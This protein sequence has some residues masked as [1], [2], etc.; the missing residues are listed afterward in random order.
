M[1]ALLEGD[2]GVRVNVVNATGGQGVT[3]H[4]RGAR[5]RP[6]GYTLTMMTVELNMLHWRGLTTV[7]PESFVPLVLFNRDPAAVFVRAD[8]PWRTLAELERFVRSGPG[9]LRASGSAQGSI[10]HLALAGWY[11]LL[12]EDPAGL[13]WLPS[14]GAASAMAELL[15]GTVDVVCCSLPEAAVQISAGQVR[16]LGVMSKERVAPA[17]ADVPAFPEQGHDWSIGGWRAVGVPRDTPPEIRSV[18][19]AALERVVGSPAFRHF[20]A[21]QGY[22]WRYEGE[23]D[24]R[25]TVAETDRV[26]GK[27][28]RE[29][30]FST[31]R[32]GRFGAMLFP[33]ALAIALLGLLTALLATGGRGGKQSDRPRPDGWARLAEGISVIVLFI[34]LVRPLGFV[35]TAGCLLGL[36]LFRLGVRP[37]TAVA[38]AAVVVPAV[39]VV[40]AVLLRVDLPRGPLGW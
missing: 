26:L 4:S 18:L 30:A 25:A 34:V 7:T 21:R 9:S 22:D 8:A 27:L 36:H 28:L 12:G 31:I 17:F 19:A 15:A 2:L 33:A 35:L 20:M 13:R 11:G 29:D 38:L 16:C 39:Y 24:A 37:R 10:W 5:A 6:D 14:Q 40:F 23:A 1:A 3:G 32:R